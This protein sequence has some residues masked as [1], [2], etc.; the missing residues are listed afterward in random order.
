MPTRRTILQ[1][2]LLAWAALGALGVRA[3]SATPP[4]I[5]TELPTAL[6]AGSSRMRFFGLSIYDAK[7][8]VT[9]GFK[10]ATYA[11]HPLALELTYLRALSGKAIAERSLTEMRRAGPLPAATEARWLAAMQ[12]AFPDVKEGDRITGVHLPAVGARFYVNRQLRSTI[13]DAEFSRLFFGI[14]LS[15]ATSEPR[16]RQELLAGVPG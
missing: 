8:W 16:L 3:Q 6:A 2:P 13:T 15:D 11:Q 12:A 7:L 14:W 5:S 9:P 10:A 1:L 4:E